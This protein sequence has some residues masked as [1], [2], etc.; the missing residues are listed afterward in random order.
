MKDLSEKTDVAS[1]ALGIDLAMGITGTLT[2]KLGSGGPCTLWWRC[3]NSNPKTQLIHYIQN[4]EKEET[5]GGTQSQVAVIHEEAAVPSFFLE[6][7]VSAK[8]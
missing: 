1:G 4:E 2:E 3:N 7:L 8:C 6:L 5:L